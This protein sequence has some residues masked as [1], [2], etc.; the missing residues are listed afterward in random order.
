[1]ANLQ[2]KNNQMRYNKKI[3]NTNTTLKALYT[4]TDNSLLSKLDE[5]K[6]E[7]S[8]EKYDLICIT[9]IKPKA[10]NIPDKD[11]LTLTGYDLHVNTAYTDLDTRGV[12]IYTKQSLE[13]TL[14]TNDT[15]SKFKDSLW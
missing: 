9:E 13:S 1:M 15:T 4:N 3:N 2:R 10:G 11:L 7:I 6:G 8:T 14:I 5:I 12:A